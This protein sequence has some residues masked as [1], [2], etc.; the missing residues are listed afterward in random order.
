MSVLDAARRMVDVVDEGL[1]ILWDPE[2]ATCEWV[3]MFLTGC[4]VGCTI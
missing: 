2:N 4:Q 1:T 3:Q